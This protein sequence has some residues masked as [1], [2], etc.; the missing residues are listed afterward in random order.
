MTA[1]S[2]MNAE[3][4][5]QIRSP[6][7][8]KLSTDISNPSFQDLFNL[9][10]LRVCDIGRSQNHALPRLFPM[11]ETIRGT[12]FTHNDWDE[13]GDLE[14]E[15]ARMNYTLSRHPERGPPA[16]CTLALKLLLH[17]GIVLLNWKH[18]VPE[19]RSQT[20]ATMR[21]VIGKMQNTSSSAGVKTEKA[22][23][24]TVR[25]DYDGVKCLQRQLY[26]CGD[27]RW[28][29]WLQSLPKERSIMQESSLKFTRSNHSTSN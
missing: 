12:L 18:H 15:R 10:V 3:Y 4:G 28:Q 19:I 24:I 25:V 11:A 27:A 16:A 23:F 7:P 21:Q 13:F 8:R 1:E 29:S 20:E 2:I 14:T 9:A 26:N 6:L 5:S 17:Q 22:D